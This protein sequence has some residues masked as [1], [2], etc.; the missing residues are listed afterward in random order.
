M[1]LKFTKKKIFSIL[2]V[3]MAVV[4]V[5]YLGWI[6]I[7]NKKS[8]KLF[9]TETSAFLKENYVFQRYVRKVAATRIKDEKRIDE[10]ELKAAKCYHEK[11]VPAIKELGF[12][13]KAKTK[14]YRKYSKECF[15]DSVRDVEE[16]SDIFKEGK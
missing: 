7:Q 1:K 5:F 8:E 16:F 15:L 9:R 3:L 11:W 10:I 6:F 13:T 12:Y 4:C 2:F 14:V